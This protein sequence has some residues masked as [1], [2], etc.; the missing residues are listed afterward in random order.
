MATCVFR[1]PQSKPKSQNRKPQITKLLIDTNSRQKG[2]Y[3]VS[4]AAS[5]W[6]CW[7]SPRLKLGGT[8]GPLF[9]DRM[10]HSVGSLQEAQHHRHKD[11]DTHSPSLTHMHTHV[12]LYMHSQT[13]TQKTI[14]FLCFYECFINH[15][16]GS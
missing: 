5:G 16:N 11:R 14:T 1:S 8:A 9:V 10:V 3:L 15:V 4:S 2:K 13:H 12:C 6:W 7:S